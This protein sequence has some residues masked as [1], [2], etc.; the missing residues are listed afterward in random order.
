MVCVSLMLHSPLTSAD[1]LSASLHPSLLCDYRY[2][3]HHGVRITDAALAAAASLSDRYLPDRH[4]PDKAIDLIDEAAS[5]VKTDLVLKP[6]ALDRAERR[7]RWV[8]RRAL[9]AACLLVLGMVCEQSLNW[10]QYVL[11][12]N[13]L[14]RAS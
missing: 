6:E 2:E 12:P 9:I 7:I 1:L 3:A 5:K 8:E 13:A 4:L 10:G 14:D 11:K